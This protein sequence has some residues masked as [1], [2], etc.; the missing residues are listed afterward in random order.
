MILSRDF[1]LSAMRSVR[2]NVADFVGEVDDGWM[3]DKVDK[4]GS[5]EVVS[6]RRK[7]GRLGLR[8]DNI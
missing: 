7:G 3:R 1:G 5:R 8:F 6:E 2:F 4:G